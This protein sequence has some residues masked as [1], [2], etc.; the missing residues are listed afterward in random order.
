MLPVAPAESVVTPVPVVVAAPATTAQ[1]EPMPVTRVRTVATAARAAAAALVVPE[2]PEAPLAEPEPRQA[3][4]LMAAMGASVVSPGPVETAA[5]EK[6]VGQASIRQHREPLEVL[7]ATQAP[8]GRV[9]PVEPLAAVADRRP[10]VWL[11]MAGTAAWVVTQD[12]AQPAVRATTLLQELSPARMAATAA[13]AVTVVQA[14]E[15]A[16]AVSVV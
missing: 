12:P 9:A 10:R 3:P 13:P 16:R 6:P 2:V 15:A 7:A 4:M 8:V 1:P 14:A 5:T 11:V